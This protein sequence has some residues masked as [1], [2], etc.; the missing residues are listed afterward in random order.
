MRSSIEKT[1]T[2]ARF[3]VRVYAYATED[4]ATV[5]GLEEGRN[6]APYVSRTELLARFGRYLDDLDAEAA[7]VAAV[8][9]AES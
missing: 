2:G 3:D 9:R 6:G 8:R 4:G 5:Y 1:L 7:G